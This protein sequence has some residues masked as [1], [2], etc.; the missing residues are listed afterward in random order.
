MMKRKGFIISSLS[1]LIILFIIFINRYANNEQKFFYPNGVLK[2]IGFLK[3]GKLNG[4]TTQ[5]HENGNIKAEVEFKDGKQDGIGKFYY[6]TGELK[7]K[8]QFKN[9][10][11]FDSAFF[12][13][14]DGSLLQKSFLVNGKEEGTLIQYYSDGTIMKSGA[15]KEG[16]KLGSWN[17]YDRLGNQVKSIFYLNDTVQSVFENSEYINFLV[18]FKIKLPVNMQKL[19]EQRNSAS[20]SANVENLGLITVSMG[21]GNF[22]EN[23]LSRQVEHEN[24]ISEKTFPKYQI[25]KE[26]IW[27][28]NL[29]FVECLGKQNENLKGEE[30]IGKILFA[31]IEGRFIIISIYIPL[32][33]INKYP[34][35]QSIL[36]DVLKSFEIQQPEII[37]D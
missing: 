23:S 15:K 18:G 26:E 21:S 13:Y 17:F 36:N 7:K 2:E 19:V 30:F 29:I 6:E 27:S 35:I 1:I 12:Y 22:T 32:N 20:Y 11:E 4:L 37:V 10:L 25:V 16:I 14:K 5:Y 28:E 9:D 34:E 3:N 33:V 31:N 24:R 8:T